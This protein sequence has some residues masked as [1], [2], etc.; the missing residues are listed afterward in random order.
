MERERRKKEHGPMSMDMQFGQP[1]KEKCT[2]VHCKFCKPDDVIKVSEK[3]TVVIEQW[4]N[5]ECEKYYDK[6]MGIVF[7]GES[8]EFFEHN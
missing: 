5:S 7:D 6:P 4:C 8:C 2:C 1:E 3:R